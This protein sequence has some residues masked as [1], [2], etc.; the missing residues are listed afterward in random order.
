MLATFENTRL[1]FTMSWYGNKS[2]VS[3]DQ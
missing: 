1:L 3:A 2:V